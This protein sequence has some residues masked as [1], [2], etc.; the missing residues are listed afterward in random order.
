MADRVRDRPAHHR[1]EPRRADSVRRDPETAGRGA[2]VKLHGIDSELQH[3]MT[4]DLFDFARQLAP[5]R[6]DRSGAAKPV[7]S[8]FARPRRARQLNG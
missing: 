7:A 8:A 6:D 1:G 2:A 3:E 5:P 4:E